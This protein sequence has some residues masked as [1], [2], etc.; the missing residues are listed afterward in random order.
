MVILDSFEVATASTISEAVRAADEGHF[1]LFILD[2]QLPDGDGA[3]LITALHAVQPATPAIFL[4]ASTWLTSQ[5][6]VAMGAAGLVV[7]GSISFV[8]DLTN[9][10]NTALNRDTE[11]A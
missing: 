9:V 4:T 2:Y 1:D 11:S 3:K 6:A 7:K 5:G 10:V 8:E